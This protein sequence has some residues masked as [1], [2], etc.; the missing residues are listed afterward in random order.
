MFQPNY[1]VVSSNRFTGM[2]NLLKLEKKEHVVFAFIHC[3][4]YYASSYWYSG[5]LKH[6]KS[7]TLIFQNNLIQYLLNLNPRPH[8]E[9]NE[10]PT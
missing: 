9:P 6:L 7:K 3:H 4:F 1:F 10:K 8:I 2:G 5:L